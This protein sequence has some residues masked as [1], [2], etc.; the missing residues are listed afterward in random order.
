MF[1]AN[2]YSKVYFQLVYKRKIKDPLKKVDSSKLF[3]PENY[4]ETHHIVP[5]SL[6]G[7]NDSNNLV[8]LK[9]KEHKIAH[10]LLVKMTE[11]KDKGK[12][13]HAF[14]K[15]VNGGNNKKYKL[16][17]KVTDRDI[18]L[19]KIYN[20]EQSSKR[21]KGVP[22][23]ESQREK[24][25][26]NSTGRLK[27][28]EEIEKRLNT[29]RI[30]GTNVLTE[31]QKSRRRGQNN[32][33]AKRKGWLWIYNS[34]IQIEKFIHP[35]ELD[36]YLKEGWRR[37][38]LRI[39]SEETRKKISQAKTGKKLTP[40]HRKKCGSPGEKNGM[41]GQTHTDEVKKK[42]SEDKKGRVNIKNIELNLQKMVKPEELNKYLEEG[43]TKGRLPMTEEHR[44]NIGL[45]VK[46]KNNFL[47]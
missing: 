16:N 20:A 18:V 1:L 13:K 8:I 17:V 47:F 38:T 33:F 15:I 30:N 2:K 42:I 25:R 41:Y 21:W 4:C 7:N 9:W 11:G 45:S 28:K 31:E 39:K 23:S 3:T 37:G 6:G 32:P 14:V 24:A 27:T 44:T 22:K 43:W 29:M 40:E 26:I 19:A 5:R 12:M 34:T 10:R 36:R 35:S 46:K